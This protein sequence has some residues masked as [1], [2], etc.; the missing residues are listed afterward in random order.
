MKKKRQTGKDEHE[1]TSSAR[2]AAFFARLDWAA[3][4]PAEALARSDSSR[5]MSEKGAAGD[6]RTPLTKRCEAASVERE[7]QRTARKI[8]K[9]KKKSRTPLE[10]NELES[11]AFS[12]SQACMVSTRSR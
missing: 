2:C 11:W 3:E 1:P 9:R 8:R 7:R 4:V 5:G 6:G 10:A 12:A